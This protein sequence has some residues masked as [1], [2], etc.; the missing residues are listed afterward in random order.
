MTT[1]HR[2]SS[3]RLYRNDQQKCLNIIDKLQSHVRDYGSR[4]QQKHVL[5]VLLPSSSIYQFLERQL[6]SPSSTYIKLAQLTEAE[7]K[8]RINK[9]IGERR[10]RLGARIEQVS[11][12]VRREVLSKS[13]LEDIYQNIINWTRDDDERREYEEKLLRHAY[14]TL[15]SLASEAKAE[16]RHKVEELARGMVIIKYPYKLAWEIVLEWK[17]GESLASWDI[18]VLRE[19]IDFFPEDGLT[20][21]LKG[22]LS[23]SLSP[24]SNASGETNADINATDTTDSVQMNGI[25]DSQDMNVEDRL[26]LMTVC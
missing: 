10:T 6:P 11:N 7:E 15:L 12:E 24:F 2:S 1:H 13:P 5:A 17:D 4:A 21:V 14:E 25:G 8:E 16:K 3:E 18:G 9:E 22:Y 23:S 20:K 26:V 19:Y